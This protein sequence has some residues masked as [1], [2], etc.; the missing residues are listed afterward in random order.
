VNRSTG[1]QEFRNRSVHGRDRELIAISRLPVLAHPRHRS[2]KRSRRDRTGQCRATLGPHRSRKPPRPATAT[3]HG[4]PDNHGTQRQTKAVNAAWT[5]FT[6]QGSLVRSQYRPPTTRPNFGA[7]V[8]SGFGSGRCRAA[9]ALGGVGWT[10]I[11]RGPR[12]AVRISPAHSVG[13]PA[14]PT[15]EPRGDTAVSGRVRT[16][17]VDCH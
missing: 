14:E 7:S 1:L 11:S 17:R 3:N 5:T 4:N 10:R 2:A 6:R 9:S 8:A 12:R 13:R 15:R 16:G